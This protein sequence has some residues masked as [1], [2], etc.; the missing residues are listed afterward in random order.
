MLT[1]KF[2]LRYAAVLIISVHFLT[3]TACDKQ[4]ANDST[5]Q[6]VSDN[7]TKPEAPSQNIHE[8]TFFG[9]VQTVSKHIKAG[10]DL[11]QK[12][13]YG[14]TPLTIAATFGKTEVAK[15]LIEGGA[16]VDAPSSD[17]STP[18]H[19]AAFFCR[20]EIVAML[21]EKGANKNVT[22]NF[23]STALQSVE[24]PF[25]QVK[26]IYDQMSKDL[27]PLGLKLDYEY[28]GTTRP[29]IASMLK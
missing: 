19:V 29:E 2:T 4:Q 1:Q 13:Q 9:N 7:A 12:D 8:A 5:E 23:G 15:A 22:N 3:L 18:L 24:V 21:L 10:T 27:G 11:N 28:L 6:A 26:P 25:D 20:T 14:S 17:G 16:N